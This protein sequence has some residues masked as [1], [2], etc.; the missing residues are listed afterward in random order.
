MEN[1]S[2]ATDEI[3]EAVPTAKTTRTSPDEQEFIKH[4]TMGIE[5][6]LRESN[7]I[8]VSLSISD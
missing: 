4:L 5:E 1:P 8:S 6:T 3:V 2:S 7:F